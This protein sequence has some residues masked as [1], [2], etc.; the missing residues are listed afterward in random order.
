VNPTLTTCL[1]GSI[2]IAGAAAALTLAAGAGWLAALAVYSLGGSLTLTI[3]AVASMPGDPPAQRR[4]GRSAA[5]A[6]PSLA[7]VLA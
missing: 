7:P 6:P 3:F 4:A 5:L 1:F 2:L